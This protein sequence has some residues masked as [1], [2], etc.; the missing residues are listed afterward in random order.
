[1]YTQFN[2]TGDK[3]LFN[4]NYEDT[5]DIDLGASK[6]ASWLVTKTKLYQGQGIQISE[7]CAEHKEH[8]Q[9]WLRE[10]GDISSSFQ[11][12]NEQNSKLVMYTT[13]CPVNVNLK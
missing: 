4:L 7:A 6:F 8:F 3:D 9:K 13:I 12:P 11:G 1:M 5:I 10:Q 2:L